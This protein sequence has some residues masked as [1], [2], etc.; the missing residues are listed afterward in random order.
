MKTSTAMKRLST[1]T[2]LAAISASTVAVSQAE[3][4]IIQQVSP[5]TKTG[6]GSIT[7]SG[8]TVNPPPTT[9]NNY[10]SVLFGQDVN[11]TTTNVFGAYFAERFQGQSL[12][13]QSP[14]PPGTGQF[15]QLSG[16][17]SNQLAL[18]VGLP[19]QNL[20]ISN[21]SILYSRVLSGLG[22][23]GFPSAEALGEGAIAVLFDR[24]Q[25]EFGFD[26]YAPNAGGSTTLS[27]FR[28][29]GSLINNITLSGSDTLSFSCTPWSNPPGSPCPPYI[30]RSYLFR[31]DSGANEI[32]GVSIY[33]YDLGGIGIAR[34]VYNNPGAPEPQ[35]IPEPSSVLGL[36]A[37]GVLGGGLKLKS[38]L[39]S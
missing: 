9:G 27:F 29:N 22:P 1:A 16:T 19:S 5:N 17:P 26:L 3:A 11:S 25:S 8:V 37:I 36:L 10:N 18:Q 20:N 13:Y 38:Q 23:A 35:D 34:I 39:K 14:I 21:Q 30:Q 31:Q 32:A 2:A 6:T 7:F 33:N 24:N 28:R 4:A 15:D 12:T